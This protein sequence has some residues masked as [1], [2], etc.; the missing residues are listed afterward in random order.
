MDQKAN[1]SDSEEIEKLRADLERER[2][3]NRSVEARVTRYVR[4]LER[5]NA[6]LE[7]FAYAASHDLQE[8][9]RMVVQFATLLER[10]LRAKFPEAVT[11]DLEVCLKHMG[12]GAERAKR[13]I[14]GLLSYSRVGRQAEFVSVSLEG[15]L[16]EA[17]ALLNGAVTEAG[18]VIARDPLPVVW[19]DLGMVSRVFLNLITNAIRFAKDGEPAR[20]HITCED[21]GDELEVSVSDSGIGIDPRHAERIFTIFARLNPEKNGTG[22][23]LA[24]CKKIVEKHGGRIWVESVPGQGATFKFTLL[25]Q[26]PGNPGV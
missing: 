6:E 20:I 17:I 19:G 3:T 25:K 9:L 23:G 1:K 11:G 13:L 24:V 12:N 18:A 26:E 7:Q 22:I 16:D 4:E 21:L 2:A 10:D 15:A 8:P 5:S 14:D